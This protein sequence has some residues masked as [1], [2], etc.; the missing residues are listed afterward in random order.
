MVTMSL[1][2]TQLSLRVIANLSLGRRKGS[3]QIELSDGPL[4]S[5]HRPS[6]DVLFR[7]VASAAGANALG[8]ILTGMGNDGAFWIARYEAR[9][10]QHDS[11]RTKKAV[12]CLACLKK[13][14]PPELLTL[15]PPWPVFQT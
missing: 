6:V 1:V 11:A 8:I 15:W 10:Q 13:Q 14:F 12:L 4:V 5:R 2:G 3:F 7:S 9:R